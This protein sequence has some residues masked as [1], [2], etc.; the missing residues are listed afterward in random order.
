MA[1]GSPN[2]V[3]GPLVTSLQCSMMVCSTTK[4]ANEVITAAAS[5]RRIKG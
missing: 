1:G 3:R 4:S 2:S 5:D